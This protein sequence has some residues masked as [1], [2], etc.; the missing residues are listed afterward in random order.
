MRVGLALSWVRDKKAGRYRRVWPAMR[1]GQGFTSRCESLHPS[2]QLYHLPQ[3]FLCV[4]PFIELPEWHNFGILPLYEHFPFP[5]H[6]TMFGGASKPAFS[7]CTTGHACFIQ[8]LVVHRL[9]VSFMT[10]LPKSL[11]RSIFS[12]IR[13]SLVLQFAAV[14]GGHRL[15]VRE[16]IPPVC[17][18]MYLRIASWCSSAELSAHYCGA[19]QGKCDPSSFSFCWIPLLRINSP[20]L[21]KVLLSTVEHET[22]ILTLQKKMGGN[23][24][25]ANMIFLSGDGWGQI[26]RSGTVADALCLFLAGSQGETDQKEQERKSSRKV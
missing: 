3:L 14:A 8:S 5:L 10:S 26:A 24:S 4:M 9:L 22:Q 19:G 15:V 21:Q 2:I 16:E 17:L 12:I 1:L 20:Q 7:Q 11:L 18:F 23:S 25:A 13:G 6:P